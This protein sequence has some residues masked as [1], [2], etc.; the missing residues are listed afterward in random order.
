M[1]SFLLGGVASCKDS[2]RSKKKAPPSLKFVIHILH[3]LET[4][5]PE[6][7][8]LGAASGALPFIVSLFSLQGQTK[9]FGFGFSPSDL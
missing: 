6:P 7:T 5:P 3:F 1:P 8:S 4:V 2:P 9:L